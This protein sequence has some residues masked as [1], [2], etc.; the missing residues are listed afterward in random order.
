MW[1]EQRRKPPSPLLRAW[2]EFHRHSLLR[3]AFYL[4]LT[5]LIVTPLAP[6]LAPYELDEQHRDSLL[7]PP[8]WEMG[9]NL[10]HFLGTDDLGRD[11]LTLLLYGS[12]STFGAALLV[13][14]VAA[15]IG[16]GL[17]VAAGFNRGVRASVLHHLFDTTL[18][19]PALLLAVAL[20]ALFGPGLWPVLLAVFL[21]QVPQFIRTTREVLRR[22]LG[23]TY[24]IAARLDGQGSTRLF[25]MTLLP[26]LAEPLF[27]QFCTSLT[28]AILDIAALGFLRLGAQQPQAEWGTMLSGGLEHLNQ[29]PWLVVLPAVALLLTVLSVHIVAEGLRQSLERGT[30][31]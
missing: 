29:A 3:Y 16:I 11:L 13:V 20:I 22:E 17:G 25:F 30:K 14:L 2:A 12:Q 1:T 21:N 5:L 8:A 27:M 6:W 28:T 23:K 19:I 10:T 26:N 24:V 15:L 4:L 9:G 7:L 18:S 31:G